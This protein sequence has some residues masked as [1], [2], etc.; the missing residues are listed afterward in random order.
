MEKLYMNKQAFL[1]KKPKN[2]FLIALLIIIFLIISLF[3]SL[4]VEVY[5]HYLTRGY[6]ECSDTCKATLV[7]PTSVDIQK[8]KINN[9]YFK[10]NILAK[11]IEIDEENVI[12]YY[13][14]IL[15]MDNSFQDKEIVDF[16]ICYN[17]Q[18]ILKKFINSIF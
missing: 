14:Y 18:R 13:L 11:T 5:D 8:L 9:K 6:I 7:V 1:R 10:L 12:S 15:Q 16:N 2:L 17:K 3:V 4:K